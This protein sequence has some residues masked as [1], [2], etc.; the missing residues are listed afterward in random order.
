MSECIFETEL[1]EECGVFGIFNAKNN[2]AAENIYLGL[3]ALQHRG[4]EACGIYCVGDNEFSLQKDDGLVHDVFYDAKLKEMNGNSGIGHVRYS[5]FGGSSYNNIQPFVFFY[6][7][8][9]FGLCHNG[10]IVNSKELKASLEQKG[11]IF[12]ATSDSEVL[13]HLIN[14]QGFENPM[15][16]IKESLNYV[17]G[18]FIFLILIDKK[19]YCARDKN[20]IRPLSIGMKDDDTYVVASETCALEAVGA[21]FVRD[22]LPGEVIEISE[23]GIKSE[24]YATGTNMSLCAMEYIYF[25]RPDSDLEGINVHLSRKEAGKLLAKKSEVKADI[26]IGVPDSS[27]SSAIGYSQ[28]SGIPYEVG[29]VKNKYMG[30]TF[31]EPTQFLRERAVALKLAAV[32]QAVSGKDI[33]LID[34]SIVRGTTLKRIVKILKE[35]NA[36]KIHIRISSPPITHPCFYGVD[37]GTFEELIMNKSTK[38]DLCE[39]LGAD[40]LEFLN[41]EDIKK[42]TGHQELCFSCFSG[43]YVTPTFN[44]L[45]K[46]N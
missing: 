6:G 40:T 3:R 17:V 28:A 26:V 27:I 18:A 37:T 39:H 22:L 30:R 7:D 34:D 21:E 14:R 29:L 32:K 16:A 45:Q 41:I 12:Q 42:S 15:E 9:N 33:V 13:A 23:N 10:N 5:T 24:F 46:E 11:S 2:Q 8:K 4:Q 38:E 36:K 44:L 35:A 25:S 20:G 1:K 19:I 43:S 31:I